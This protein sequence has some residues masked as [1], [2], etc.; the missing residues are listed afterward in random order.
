M[1]MN[2]SGINNQDSRINKI[3]LKPTIILHFL[4]CINNHDII[5]TNKYSERLNQNKRGTGN[6]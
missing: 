4:N 5:Q 2:N 3:A 6:I 1:V